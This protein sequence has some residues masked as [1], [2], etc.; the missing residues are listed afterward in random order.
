M[1]R[2]EGVRCFVAVLAAF[3]LILAMLPNAAS[4]V[5]E[6]EA[7]SHIAAVPHDPF[8]I[9]G[10]ANFSDTASAE[11]WSGDGSSGSPYIIEN[12]D[13]DLGPSPTA[14]INITGTSVH[15][16]I[17]ECY[18]SGPL[19]TPSYGVYLD[20]VANGRIDDTYCNGFSHGIYIE[21]GCN[22]ITASN[23]NCSENSYGIYIESSDSNTVINNI[24]NINYFHGIYVNSSDSNSV[25][26][27]ICNDNLFH[28]IF[29]HSSNSCIVND[30]T[31]NDNDAYGAY[32]YNC[33][34]STANDNFCNINDYG[35]FLHTC[36]FSTVNR[37]TCNEN[38]F[39][40]IYLL[41]S[42]NSS[43]ANNTCNY[44][45][46]G[47][48]IQE[49]NS[50]NVTGNTCIL[51]ELRGIALQDCDNNLLTLNTVTNTTAEYGL[52]I[53]GGSDNNNITWNAFAHNAWENCA[54]VGTSNFIDHNYYSDY[55]GV[56]ADEDGIGDTAHTLPLSNSDS[57]PLMYYPFPPEWEQTPTD[58]VMEFGLVFDYML[59]FVVTA[60]TAPYEIFI[61]D[62]LNFAADIG[63]TIISRTALDVGIYPV[64]V[65]AT[66]IYGFTTVGAFMLT[67]VDTTPPIVTDEEDV[68][69]LEGESSGYELQWTLSDLS[70]LN[71][72]LYRNGTEVTSSSMPT[73]AVYFSTTLEDLPVGVHNYTIVAIDIYDNM[74]S[75]TVLVT[76]RPIPILETLLPWLVIGAA[77]VVVVILSVVIFRKRKST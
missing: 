48:Y 38:A 14:A 6:S 65:V 55:G 42:P 2:K 50:N 27:N 13:I 36:D 47:M 45:R 69:F 4:I 58:Q 21:N 56:D 9:I 18:L 61:D 59:E 72:V 74:A 19:A 30:N 52:F 71:F 73:T 33:N 64:Q 41:Q 51:N 70:P 34:S 5:S 35:L 37:N 40:G 8:V 3:S 29:L 12:L 32:L 11:G 66:N 25:I 77:A 39:S 44:N 49:M 7:V 22:D 53:T 60:T 26:N 1:Q 16:I 31:C 67:V 15:F 76:I 62:Y 28:G 63:D 24:C 17:R 23:N 57:N 75:D 43:A 54:D 10:D 20:N 46:E 68:S